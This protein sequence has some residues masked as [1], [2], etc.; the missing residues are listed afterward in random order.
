MPSHG[1]PKQVGWEEFALY[2]ERGMASST[3]MWASLG[4]DTSNFPAYC[5]KVNRARPVVEERQARRA[6]TAVAFDF[7]SLKS[8]RQLRGPHTYQRHADLLHIPGV[9]WLVGRRRVPW[10]RAGGDVR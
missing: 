4:F 7:D 3:Q 8:V 5:C 1:A 2:N 6:V 9:R 10:R